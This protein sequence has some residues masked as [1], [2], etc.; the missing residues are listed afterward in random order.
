[1]FHELP[2][3]AQRAIVREVGRLL[4]PGGAFIL[5]DSLQLGDRPALDATL[6]LFKNLN[7]PFYER[8][9][10]TSLAELVREEAGLVPEWKGL[11]SATKTLSFR[12]PAAAPPAAPPAPPPAASP[13]APPAV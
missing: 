6:P 5:T 9:V 1:M 3:S 4:R 2:E 12:K 10:Q 11:R 7:E 8:F 13:V